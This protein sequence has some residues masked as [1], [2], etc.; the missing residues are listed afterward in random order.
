VAVA[1]VEGV[2]LIANGIAVAV[3][4]LRDGINAP[5]AV[6]SPVGIL[7]EVLLYL[8]FG[9]AMLWIARGL[10]LGRRGVLTPFVLAQLLALTVSVPLATGG[11]TASAVGWAI[12]LGCVAGLVSWALL[13][14]TQHAGEPV[15]EG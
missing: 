2:A 13:Y 15:A 12:T 1:A 4:V 8:G 3:L 10:V 9:L 6:A 11:G 14:R 5:D 7:L